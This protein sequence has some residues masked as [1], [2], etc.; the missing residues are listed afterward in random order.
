MNL[1][2]SIFLKL[3]ATPRVTTTLIP[4]SIC[5]TEYCRTAKSI[6]TPS[7]NIIENHPEQNV[8]EH[9]SKDTII[10][11]LIDDWIIR[12][13]SKP[14][15]R[16]ENERSTPIGQLT[17]QE[18]NVLSN[19]SIISRQSSLKNVNQWTVSYSFHFSF[20]KLNYVFSK[21]NT[22]VCLFSCVKE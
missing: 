2:F 20:I 7:V 22:S 14:F 8:F 9:K 13:S 16:N 11:H 17:K 1:L 3:S 4:L 6:L 5:P 19:E 21:Y 18:K 15:Q 10:T 12:E